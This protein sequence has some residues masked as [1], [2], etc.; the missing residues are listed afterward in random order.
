M[1]YFGNVSFTL[2]VR[3]LFYAVTPNESSFEKVEDVP[4]YLNEV[5]TKGVLIHG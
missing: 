5:R 1:N 3:R 4:D 2:G